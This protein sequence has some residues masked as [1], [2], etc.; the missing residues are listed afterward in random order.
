MAV[1]RMSGVALSNTDGEKDLQ[2]EDDVANMTFAQMQA[3]IRTNT[4]SPELLQ[5]F[6]QHPE[7]LEMVRQREAALPTEIR[8]LDDLKAFPSNLL[9]TL[10]PDPVAPVIAE[11]GSVQWH[12]QVTLDRA[13]GDLAIDE[14]GSLIQYEKGGPWHLAHP[15]GR[16]GTRE[17]FAELFNCPDGVLKARAKVSSATLVSTSKQPRSARRVWYVLGK[18]GSGRRVCGFGFLDESGHVADPASPY[19]AI[20]GRDRDAFPLRAFQSSG[21][22]FA[23]DWRDGEDAILEA[24][25]KAADVAMDEVSLQWDEAAAHMNL[26]H[27]GKTNPVRRDRH[28]AQHAMVLVLQ[29]VFGQTHAIRLINQVTLGDDTAWFMVESPQQWQHLEQSNPHLRWFFTPVELLPDV[30]NADTDEIAEAGRRYADE[31]A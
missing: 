21:R 9:V 23:V 1:D 29:Q 13:P 2:S 28:G 22:C 31:A 26:V 17:E 30:F 15:Y 19:S 14:F 3:R 7:Y 20:T 27:A 11:D 24:F 6:M 5:R 12:Y 8:S 10:T 18:A 25:A 4:A 16:P